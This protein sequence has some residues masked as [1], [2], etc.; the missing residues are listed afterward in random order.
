MTHAFP[1][2]RSSDRSALCG[3]M[4]VDALGASRVHGVMLP[5]L[6]TS[7]ESLNDAAQTAEALGVRYDIMPISSAVEGLTKSLAAISDGGDSGTADRKRT[8]LN[9]SH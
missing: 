6:Y 8:R 1:T 9:S 7:N 3:S 5:Y 2:R 4:S